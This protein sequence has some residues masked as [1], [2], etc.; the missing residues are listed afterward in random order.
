MNNKAFISIEF[1]FSIF[2]LL[3]IA[4]GLIV[5][6]DNAINSSLNIESNFNHRIILDNVANTI[7]QVDSNGESYSQSLK[8][9]ETNKNYVIT[10]DGRKLMIEFDNKK[11]ESSLPFVNSYS[12]YKLYPGHSYVVEKVN[13]K[14]MIK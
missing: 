14:I 4:T 6:S 13:G 3:I 8:L 5:Y 12:K 10:L 2:I 7:N 11:A 1:L 9:P